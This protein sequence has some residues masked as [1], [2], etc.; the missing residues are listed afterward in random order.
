MIYTAIFV[1]AFTWRI[2]RGLSSPDLNSSVYAHSSNFKKSPVEVI[3]PQKRI[4]STHYKTIHW[5]EYLLEKKMEEK[6]KVQQ[7]TLITLSRT[8]STE[9]Y[10]N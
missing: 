10:L 9:F 4:L 1:I 6:G 7:I 2:A 3:I 5:S 8:K